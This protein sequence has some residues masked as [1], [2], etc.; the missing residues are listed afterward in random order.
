MSENTSIFFGIPERRRSGELQ[1]THVRHAPTD[2]NDLFL[3]DGL[4][5]TKKQVHYWTQAVKPALGEVYLNKYNIECA[6]QAQALEVPEN[7]HLSENGLF[8]VHP[9]NN[10]KF[11]I[12]G[13]IRVVALTE[14]IDPHRTGRLVEFRTR[15]KQLKRMN[16]SDDWLSKDGDLIR[17]KLMASGFKI[18]TNNFA[19]R[20]LNQYLNSIESEES[21]KYV[22]LT[23]WYPN[24]FLS[25]SGVIGNNTSIFLNDENDDAY[26]CESGTL[27]EWKEKVAKYCVGNSRLILSVSFSFASILIK[28]CGRENC[29]IHLVG[30]SSQGKTSS[31]YLAA[32]V[33][34]S[35]EYI[36]T[37]RSTDNA[38]EGLAISHNDMLLILDEMAEMNPHKIGEAAYMLCNGQGKSRF[39]STISLRKQHRW[40]LG[41]LSTGEIDITTHMESCGRKSYAG[42]EL[43]LLSI[44]AKSSEESFGIFENIHEFESPEFFANYLKDAAGSYYGTA[45]MEFVKKALI[46][47]QKIKPWYDIGFRDFSRE[48]SPEKA[49]EQDAR[50]FRVFYFIGFA[51]EL[52]TKYGITGWNAG[53]ALSASLQCFRSWLENKGGTGN[54]ESKKILEQVKFFLELHGCSR[55]YD[56]HGPE[57]QSINNMAG[58]RETRDG[59]TIFYVLPTIFKKEICR[60]LNYKSAINLLV[61]NN[62]L[63]EDDKEGYYRPKRTP[64]GIK[65]LYAIRGD[66]I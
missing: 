5:A 59:E 58:Y 11:Y 48:H 6:Q 63:S 45:F 35:L 41:I 60:G 40:R 49:S 56:L 28:P 39:N 42:Q 66:L 31:L 61:K 10:E 55:F 22:Q 17:A 24:C 2:F 14:E 12:C 32:S 18:S 36:K 23:G 50:A 13:H 52:A 27:K 19:R 64:H 7:F 3:L 44:P 30:E 62:A 51:G 9:K 20:M 16:I 47:Y 25:S 46:D 1:K 26:V 8:Y 15:K 43:R 21:A 53:D 38:L 29:G 54:L 37:W 57:S 65:R 34:G 33:F 4:D